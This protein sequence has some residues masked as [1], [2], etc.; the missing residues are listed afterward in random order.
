MDSEQIIEELRDYLRHSLI[1]EQSAMNTCK[2][3]FQFYSEMKLRLNHRRVSME[4]DTLCKHISRVH[5]FEETLQKLDK[6]I[7]KYKND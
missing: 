5:A 2:K 1:E 3:Q 4:V 6:L 7:E